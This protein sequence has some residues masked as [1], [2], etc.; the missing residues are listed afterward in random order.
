[1]SGGL[2]VLAPGLHTTLQDFGRFG[3][4]ALG[5]P[6]SGALD[7]D[8]L[9]LANALVGN[10]PDEAALEVLH[11]GPVLE[12]TAP[13]LR[14]ALA[15]YGGAILLDDAEDRR[16]PAWR[17]VTLP[18]GARLRV[19][20]G[21]D[22]AAGYLAIGGGFAVPPLAGS[23]STYVRGG[24]GGW[25]GRALAEGDEIPARQ[26]SAPAGA[27]RR[28]PAPPVLERG[29]LRVVLGPQDDHFTE[30]AI[31]T[32]CAAEFVVTPEADRMGLRLDGPVLEHRRGHDIVSD[33]TA[34]GALQ[35][36]GSGRPVL[37][38]ADRQ[39]TGGYPK[40]A[41]VCTADLPRAGQL[42]P[43]DRVSFAAIEVAAAQAA[44]REHEAA[45]A[46][47]IGGIVPI[48]ARPDIATLRRIDLISG[49]VEADQA[50]SSNG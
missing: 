29:K 48:E 27:E 15:A 34:A 42:R 12:V 3:A 28:L 4:Q 19:L 1:M 21:R 10:A 31:A 13:A 7:R 36:P 33:G 14:L 2:R 17:S 24:L 43:G 6:V 37:L 38:L 26:V 8:L 23:R 32:L 25:Q 11:V 20:A 45:L 46:A 16:V 30:A 22:T 40:I 47:L 35:V 39:T 18:R 49:V 9:R 41:V 44:R 5:M 50:N